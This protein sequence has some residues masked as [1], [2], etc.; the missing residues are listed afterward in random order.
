MQGDG[1]FIPEAVGGLVDGVIHDFPE[2]MMQT[3]GG[4]GTDI[5]TGPHTDGFQTFQYLNV[6]SGIGLRCHVVTP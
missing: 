6:P 2:E 3:A 5:H 4:S 1:H